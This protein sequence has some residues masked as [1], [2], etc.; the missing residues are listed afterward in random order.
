MS[1][2]AVSASDSPHGYTLWAVWRRDPDRPVTEPDD[3][4][5]DDVVQ[6]VEES[7]IAVRGFYDVSGLRVAPV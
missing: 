1:D 6:F 4:E 3:R 5:L 2:P 7:G